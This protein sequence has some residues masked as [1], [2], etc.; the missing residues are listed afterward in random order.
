[1]NSFENEIFAQL[2]LCFVSVFGVFGMLCKLI[3]KRNIFNEVL[4]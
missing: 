2:A 4:R 1:M 3:P